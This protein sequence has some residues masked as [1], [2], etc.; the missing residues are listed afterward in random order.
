MA[1]KT[2]QM[3]EREISELQ[4]EITKL[5]SNVSKIE[6]EKDY[7]FVKS[8]RYYLL[9]MHEERKNWDCYKELESY[10]EQMKERELEELEE[11]E[12]KFDRTMHIYKAN[13]MKCRINNGAY[14]GA[15][16]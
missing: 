2:K 9:Y 15:N 10:Y 14:Y 5:K 1:R 12:K 7:W 8:E 13:Q 4:F 16:W 11:M 6:G 3:L